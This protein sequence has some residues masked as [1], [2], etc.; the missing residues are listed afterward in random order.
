MLNLNCKDAM[1]LDRG[2]STCL[3]ANNKII[4]NPADEDEVRKVVSVITIRDR[5][6]KK[7][8]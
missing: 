6:R 1:N 3:Y 7:Q 4:S 8:L 2:G 5:Y